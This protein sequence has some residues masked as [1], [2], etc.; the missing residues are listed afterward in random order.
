MARKIS[1]GAV[2]FLE[3]AQRSIQ[4]MRETGF[5][6]MNPE[7]ARMVLAQF[8]MAGQFPP[9]APAISA[10]TPQAGRV[11]GEF[12]LNHAVVLSQAYSDDALNGRRG[13]FRPGGNQ[14]GKL[15]PPSYVRTDLERRIS[16]FDAN[17][18]GIAAPCEMFSRLGLLRVDWLKGGV[19]TA[20]L[21]LVLGP[22]TS[23]K[24]QLGIVIKNGIK[25][26][27]SEYDTG[28]YDADGNFDAKVF[29]RL[30]AGGKTE[31]TEKE[32]HR[33]ISNKMPPARNLWE[34]LRRLGGKA[35]SMAEFS[36]LFDIAADT[37]KF[38]EGSERRAIRKETLKNMYLGYLFYDIAN[39]RIAGRSSRG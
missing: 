28:I 32:I 4:R 9:L 22:L 6:G 23:G 11:R 16:F 15:S 12:P 27:H 25:V 13:P 35:K 18:D 21:N 7:E 19:V 20:V 14:P 36:L 24:L 30:F 2:R 8:D 5:T 37:T 29:E 1:G 33:F 39:E 10:A 17:G 38:I 34:E 31:I 26:R 3:H